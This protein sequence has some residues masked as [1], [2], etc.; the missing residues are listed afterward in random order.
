MILQA[1][2]STGYATF[3]PNN[4]GGVEGFIYETSKRISQFNEIGVLYGDPELRKAG[5]AELE[6]IKVFSTPITRF[7]ESIPLPAIGIPVSL[8]NNLFAASRLFSAAKQLDV[9][10]LHL[11]ESHTQFLI[12]KYQKTPKVFTFHGSHTCI[13]Y[14]RQTLHAKI[15]AWK[16]DG[17][18]AK[19]CDHLTAIST[20]S[21]RN[22]V[23]YTGF[24]EEDVSVV[25][26]GVDAN[27][28]KRSKEDETLVKQLNLE[29][30]HVLICVTRLAHDKGLDLTLNALSELA[31][32]FPDITC[33]FCG[34]SL[35]DL[36][37]NSYGKR[38][39]YLI[40]KNNLWK[41]VSFLGK[42][43]RQE[44]PNYL[45]L[46]DVFVHPARVEAFGLAVAEA[47]ACELPPVCLKN[48]GG[49][50][51]MVDTGRNG[52]LC[53]SE[54]PHDI[55]EKIKFLLENPKTLRSFGGRARKTIVN[56]F[57]WEACVHKLRHIYGSI[58]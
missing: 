43:S 50:D 31:K 26:Y 44:L 5:I 57:S 15:L 54:D 56:N 17:Y 13:P 24:P 32:K 39:L 20:L 8:A 21:K 25:H 12:A 10:L 41:N 53:R 18:A 51:D 34:I 3:P 22:I 38:M 2:P 1:A 55:A 23:A 48:S 16:F 9:D 27:K 52:F 14:G 6:G 11:H 7:S 47:M 58:S 35:S 49:P 45:L 46:A 33:L 42:I 36:Q 40:S 19:Y 30:R 37:R 29:G 4:Y 28:F